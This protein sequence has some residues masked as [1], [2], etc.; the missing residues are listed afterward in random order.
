MLRRRLPITGA[1]VALFLACP[2]VGRGQEAD[3]PPDTTVVPAEIVMPADTIAAPAD[4]IAA[5][6]DSS[7]LAADTAAGPTVDLTN[8]PVELVDRVVAVVG[9]TVVLYTEILEALLQAQA[10]GEAPP[11]EG[12]AAFDSLMQYTLDYLIDQLVL[13]QRAREDDFSIADD[14]LESETD[15]RFREIRSS[16]PSGRDF[17]AAITESGRTLVQYRLFLRSQ[18]RAQLMIQQYRQAHLGDLPTVS[19]SDEE[20]REWFDANLEGQ[21]RPP[22]ITFEQV[23]M[24]PEPD[25]AAEAGARARAQQALDELRGGAAFE[26][27]ARQYSEDPA[28]RNE[29]GDLGWVQRSRVDP[30]FA[31]AAWAARTGTPIGPIR[32]QFG[33][34]IIK[35][36]NVRGGERKIRHILVRPA[37]DEEDV[38]RARTLARAVADSARSGTPLQALARHHGMPNEPVRVPNAPMDRLAEGGLG[39]YETHLTS[40]VPGEVVG[41]F[42]STARGSLRLVVLKVTEFTPQGA[43]DFDEVRDDIRQGL[44]QQKAFEQFVAE[45][46]DEVYVDLRL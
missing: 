34:H 18:V 17:E 42:D 29:G 25:S 44:T 15:R 4:T 45:L 1:A 28:N 31:R 32:T 20:I 11:A 2:T 39:E 12:T 38:A 5:P 21:D 24:R 43:V 7:A 10:A 36:E 27:V 22:T 30:D 46:R 33:Y 3:A 9:D 19:V 16:F 6:T 14:V 40:P 26:V 41:P 13:L 23:V 35:V 37:V 8:A